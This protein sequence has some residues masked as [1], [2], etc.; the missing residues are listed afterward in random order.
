VQITAITTGNNYPSLEYTKAP[1]ELFAIL[2][3][4]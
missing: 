1:S 3:Q 4:I 2:K